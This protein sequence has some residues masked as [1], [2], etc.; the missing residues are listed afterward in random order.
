[1]KK[2]SD[3]NGNDICVTSKLKVMLIADVTDIMINVDMLMRSRFQRVT[4]SRSCMWPL[5]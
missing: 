5:P 2:S 3:A 1:M 4:P